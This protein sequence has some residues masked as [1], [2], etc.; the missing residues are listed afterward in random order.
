MAAT[1]LEN[2][3]QLFA[4]ETARTGAEAGLCSAESQL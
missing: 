1:I 3:P 4:T 2:G